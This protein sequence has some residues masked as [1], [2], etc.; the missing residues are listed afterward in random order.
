MRDKYL[1]IT[2][3]NVKVLAADLYLPRELG[4]KSH[5]TENS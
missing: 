2:Y 4:E 3:R 1:E 5:R